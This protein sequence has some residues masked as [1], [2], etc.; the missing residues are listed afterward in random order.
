MDLNFKL[1]YNQS[2]SQNLT[3]PMSRLPRHIIIND[4]VKVSCLLLTLSHYQ[5][6]GLEMSSG[7]EDSGLASK[8][9]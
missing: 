7:P 9:C 4:T 3:F 8:T 5:P 2:S 6:H 1:C